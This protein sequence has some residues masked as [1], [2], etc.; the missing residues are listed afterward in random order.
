[1]T[2][3][4]KLD[5]QFR[6]AASA[7]GLLDAAYDVADSPVGELLVAATDRGVCW[8]EFPPH[9]TLERLSRQVGSRL[10]RVPRRLTAVKRELDEYFAGRRTTFDVDVDIAFVPSFQQRVLRELAR[11]P[12][13]EVTTYGALAGSIGKPRAARA[14][15]GALNRNPVPIILPCHRVVGSTGSLVG[16]AGGL[17]RKQALLKLEGAA[18]V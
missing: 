10:L 1:M 15:G 2:V 18:L 7:A 5:T 6:S 9:D 14:V 16:Y 11:V 13:G 3:P 4:A 17:D 12:Y 8:I